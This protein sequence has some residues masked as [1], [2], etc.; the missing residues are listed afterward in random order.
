MAKR[1]KRPRDPIALALLFSVAT[2]EPAFA[3]QAAT[4]TD[5]DAAAHVGQT[6]TV[7]GLVAVVY[8]SPRGGCVLDFESAYPNEVFLGVV[9]SSSAMQFGDLTSYRGKRVQ[10]TSQ[11]RLDRG[12]PEIILNSPDQLRPAP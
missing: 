7:E 3:D 8:K 11:I 12:K 10:I 4:I 9:F 6:V 5:T 2:L 1:L